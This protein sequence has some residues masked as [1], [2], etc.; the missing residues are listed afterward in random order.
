MKNT[1]K[2]FPILSA[3]ALLF[4]CSEPIDPFA[5][6]QVSAHGDYHTVTFTSDLDDGG[7][8][9]TL[10][11]AIEFYERQSATR[12]VSIYL[13]PNFDPNGT[14]KYPVYYLLHG[15]AGDNTTWSS[16][17]NIGAVADLLIERGE[18]EPMIIVMP[19]GS[20]ALGGSFYTN[21]VEIWWSQL[22]QTFK[23]KDVFGRFEDYIVGTTET[24]EKS[25]LGYVENVAQL[26]I[27]GVTFTL[28]NRIDKTK[29]AIGGDSMG[30]YGAF[31]L[32]MKHP[33]LFQSVSGHATPFSFDA[34]FDQSEGE[35][36]VPQRIVKENLPHLN[37]SYP[38]PEVNLPGYA[39]TQEQFDE[40]TD[41]LGYEPWHKE[42]FIDDEGNL[43]YDVYSVDLIFQNP[44][45]INPKRL[46][47]E[48]LLSVLMFT[49]SSAFSPKIANYGAMYFDYF[50]DED[51]QHHE[52]NLF[53][54]EGSESTEGYKALEFAG[55]EVP[56]SLPRFYK[57]DFDYA[58][59]TYFLV[60]FDQRNWPSEPFDDAVQPESF[61]ECVI[62]GEV[63]E[64]I[65][66]SNDCDTA[67]GDWNFI[68]FEIIKG[69]GEDFYTDSTFTET[70]T[71]PGIVDTIKTLW[72]K[73][74]LWNMVFDNS[75][76]RNNLDNLRIYFDCGIYDDLDNTDDQLGVNI[77][78]HNDWFHN[79]L[80]FFA[81]EHEYVTY[82]GTYGNQ[83][84]YQMDDDLMFHF[85]TE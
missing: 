16:K 9:K 57:T 46:G 20:N 72:M 55:V 36:S 85:G 3:I 83:L 21:S 39:L 37:M 40:L 1:I 54:T 61:F 45:E 18:I 30:G 5:D 70:T 79:L 82:P 10:Y 67:G 69:Y 29:R 59:S 4:W 25:V 41:A 14:K 15:F 56:L 27:D 26:T 58:D 60:P 48:T 32:A 11:D 84:Y 51:G 12:D 71:V 19:D 35:N 66:N 78:K 62:D 73:H 7:Y 23:E 53:T 74:D 80:E 43:R 42:P 65:T 24:D 44:Y 76:Y 63:D 77:I 34:I 33:E 2:L 28:G 47:A 49:L 17:R 64:N 52:Y 68:H 50:G 75:D 8:I 6:N 13:P 22:T 38:R 81:I 31:K